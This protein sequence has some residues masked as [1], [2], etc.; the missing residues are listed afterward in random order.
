[1]VPGSEDARD[2]EAVVLGAHYDHVG[3]GGR[4]SA[5][6]DR[7]GEIHNGADDNASGVAALIEV[8][9]AAASDR[10]RFSRSLVFVAFAGEERGLFGSAH[11]ATHPVIP[12]ADTVAMI[13]LD[14]IG[15]SN[16][17]LEVSGLNEVPSLAPDVEAAAAV[18]GLDVRRGGAGA[19]RSDDSSFIDKNVPSLHFF[20]G[21]HADYH[22]PTDD[23]PRIDATGTARVAT[24]A[25][26]LAARLSVRADR[27]KFVSR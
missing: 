1:M 11:Y 2:E 22:R 8:A 6:P 7:T 27:P 14:M 26:E 20:T 5:A 16:G 24:L 4:Y 10:G 21:F 23:W 13:N 15:R 17:R 3:L 19:G 9:R 12:M 18:A 25:L